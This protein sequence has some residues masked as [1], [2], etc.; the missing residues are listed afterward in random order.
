MGADGIF[1]I[2]HYDESLPRQRL[3]IVAIAL[4]VGLEYFDSTCFSFFASY[5]AGG[6]NASADE[7]VWSTSVYAI[8]CI[9]RDLI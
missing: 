7:L 8:T 5:I 2:T 1:T 3:F 9:S 6:V 4:F